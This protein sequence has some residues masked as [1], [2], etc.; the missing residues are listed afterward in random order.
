MSL[1]ARQQAFM[2]AILDDQ[3]ELPAGWGARQAAG[4]EIYR[5]N[6]RASVVAALAATF[7]RTQRWVGQESFRRAA[8]HHVILHPP[9]SWTIDAVGHGFDATLA[10]LFA[11]DPEVAELAALEWAMHQAFVA[12]DAASL[13]MADFARQTAHFSDEDW[14]RLGFVFVP[15]TA[16][17]SVVHD[18]GALWHALAGEDFTAPEIGLDAPQ[19]MLVWREGLRPVF[20]LMEEADGAA[21]AIATGGGTFGEICAALVARLGPDEGTARAGRLLGQWLQE[22]L[23]ARLKP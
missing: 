15:A 4:L 20:R 9:F 22:G 5:N 19:A 16:L 21:V 13:T 11:N 10:G 18:V 2:A 23:L 12:G 14:G 6:Y 7:E 8:A 1:A 3:A 17:L